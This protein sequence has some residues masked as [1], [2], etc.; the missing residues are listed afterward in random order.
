MNYNQSSGSNTLSHM[1]KVAVNPATS[2]ASPPQSTWTPRH[3]QRAE[4][5]SQ[6]YNQMS[7]GPPARSPSGPTYTQLNSAP[8]VARGAAAGMW[9]HQWQGGSHAAPETPPGSSGVGAPAN[10]NSSASGA[11]AAG[12]P[13][14][15]ELSEM[16]QMLG[17]SETASFEDLSMF[18]TFP[19]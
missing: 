3:L 13:P 9:C 11:T 12:H 14:Q 18:N 19:E 17:Q 4:S 16:L 8:V 10:S 2:N 6:G 5:Y 1:S 15:Q 7:P